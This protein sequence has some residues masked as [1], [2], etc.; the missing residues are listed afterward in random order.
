[1]R[2]ILLTCVADTINANSLDAYVLG[3]PGVCSC[4]LPSPLVEPSCASCALN[5]RRFA[6]VA[7][8]E[9]LIVTQ[10]ITAVA[11]GAS[12]A[13][14][15][16]ELVIDQD[17]VMVVFVF[18]TNPVPRWSLLC[19]SGLCHFTHRH[20]VQRFRA[21][22]HNRQHLWRLCECSRHAHVPIL[23]V[24]LLVCWRLA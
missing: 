7:S 14:S 17:V 20:Y 12:L 5:C 22:P 24:V 16:F 4:S 21:R 6:S 3:L 2:D 8:L 1:M 23:H 18:S 10:A 11:L 13:D 15:C 19:A 9:S